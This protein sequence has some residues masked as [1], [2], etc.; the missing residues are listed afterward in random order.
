MKK[1]SRNNLTI[2]FFQ[3]EDDQKFSFYIEDEPVLTEQLLATV[4]NKRIREDK[5]KYAVN[6]IFDLIKN[7]LL[8]TKKVVQMEN[9]NPI[10]EL[11]E[12]VQRQ[13]GSNIETKVTGKTGADHM[14]T[15]SVAIILP[16]GRT[17]EASG[18]NKRIAKQK[19][20]EKALKEFNC[21]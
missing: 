15:V 4:S 6:G 3:K 16:G 18:T 20:A 9:L 1:F 2:V 8:I 14:P 12:L 7:N 21:E 13:F 17:F 10:I 11:A 19:A 5:I